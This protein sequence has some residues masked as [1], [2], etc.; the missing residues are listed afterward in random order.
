VDLDD[1]SFEPMP[2][3]INTLEGGAGI[4]AAKAVVDLGAHAVLTGYIGPNAARVLASAGLNTITG[5][6]GTVREAAN[7]YQKGQLRPGQSAKGRDGFDM[8]TF[9][10]GARFRKT[11]QGSSTGFGMG[12]GQDRGARPGMGRVSNRSS[13]KTSPN[14]GTEGQELAGQREYETVSGD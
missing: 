9:R 4:Q 11:S 7:Q 8:E 12:G 2:N 13:N 5:V 14:Q 1:M 6:S 3:G 10:H